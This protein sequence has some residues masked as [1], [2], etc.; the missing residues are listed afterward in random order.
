MA[1][2][3][4]ESTLA[5][6]RRTQLDI[7]AAEA[8]A[9]DAEQRARV[10]LAEAEEE[11][12]RAR[13]ERRVAAAEARRQA[14]VALAAIEAEIAEMRGALARE[15]LTGPRLDQAMTRIDARLAVMPR[16]EG[17]GGGAAHAGPL[18]GRSTRRHGGRLAGHAGGPR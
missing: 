10:A 1:Q 3:E 6:I 18:A 16:V 8:R 15:T 11:R 7:T 13:A 14:E 4:F 2:Q 17:R 5:S 12:R 9:T